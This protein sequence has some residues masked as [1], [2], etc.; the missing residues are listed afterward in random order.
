M[1]EAKITVLHLSTHNEQC[2]IAIYQQNITDSMGHDRRIENVFFDISPNKLKVMPPAEFDAA[3]AKLLEQLQGFDILH[4]QH[5]YSFYNG[6]Q[7][8]KIV[9]GARQTGKKIM[10]TL[11]TPPHAHRRGIPRSAPRGKHPRSWLHARRVAKDDTLFVASYL[12]PLQGADLLVTTSSVSIDS[13]ASYGVDPS[14]MRVVALPVPDTDKSQTSHEIAEKL[15]VQEGDTVLSTVGFLSETKGIIPALKALCFLPQTY[16]LALIGGSHPSGQNDDFY[17]Q[18][19]DT[20]VSL[21][22]QDR[23]Y[24]TGYVDDD[25]RRDALVRETDICLYPYDK[26]YYDYVSSAALTN[27]IANEL[28]IVAYKTKT[29]QEA[30]D[31]VPFINFCQSANY[32]EIARQVQVLDRQQSGERTQQ[33]AKQ[34]SVA[35]QAAQFS[36][37]YLELVS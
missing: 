35:A 30:N 5:E 18:V 32:Y 27:A 8:Q 24:I 9:D 12:Q 28:P 13:F 17:D 14:K 15:H 26:G 10:F 2:G 31:A 1:V 16:K 36:Q 29:F 23:V 20:I 37:I 7:L 21:G 3:L 34:F 19:C 11:H 4:I 25:A 6:D 33:Y 22:L